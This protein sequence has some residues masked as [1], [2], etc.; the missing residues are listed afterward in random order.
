MLGVVE[1]VG[2][3]RY[4]GTRWS[5]SDSKVPNVLQFQRGI[6]LSIKSIVHMYRNAEYNIG[7]L[8]HCASITFIN[9]ANIL[10]IIFLNN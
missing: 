9:I 3:F 1:D 10:K 4:F 2:Q 8:E 5:V 7:Y 6:A